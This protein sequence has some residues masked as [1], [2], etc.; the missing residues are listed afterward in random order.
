MGYGFGPGVGKPGKKPVQ[1]KHPVKP[2][3]AEKPP[4][5][6]KPKK[7][8]KPPFPFDFGA[9]IPGNKWNK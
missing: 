2:P 8:N 3:V 7:T 4:A 6:N 5:P 1:E 9:I